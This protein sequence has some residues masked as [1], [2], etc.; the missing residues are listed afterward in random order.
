MIQQLQP[1]FSFFSKVILTVSVICQILLGLLA[2]WLFALF[3]V[4][5]IHN[6]LEDHHTLAYWITGILATGLIFLIQ[7]YKKTG[8]ILSGIYVITGILLSHNEN[9]RELVGLAPLLFR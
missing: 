1:L 8:I 9:F 5:L 2:V 6:P 4:S 7:K 3:V